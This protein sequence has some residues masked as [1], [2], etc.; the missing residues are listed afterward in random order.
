MEKDLLYLKKNINNWKK[1]FI[2]FMDADGN[3][4]VFKKKRSNK[5]ISGDISEYYNVGYGIHISLSERDIILL[6]EI[7][8]LLN[9]INLL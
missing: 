8:N 3:F 2:G 5:L 1:W 7:N 9:F 4:Q 6:E